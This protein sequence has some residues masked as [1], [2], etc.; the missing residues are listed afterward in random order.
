[1]SAGA[2]ELHQQILFILGL[3]VAIPVLVFYYRRHNHRRFRPKAGEMAMVCLFVV[4][5]CGGGAMLMGSF[6]DD[7]DQFKVRDDLS[8]APSGDVWANTAEGDDGAEGPKNKQNRTER[9][10]ARGSRNEPRGS[11]REEKERR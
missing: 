10:S 4:L 8:V 3:L 6:L 5:L 1:M 11:G 9:E 2:M 7:P